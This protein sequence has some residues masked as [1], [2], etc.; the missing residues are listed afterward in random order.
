MANLHRMAHAPIAVRG[1]VRRT[2]QV[3][4]V[5]FRP[6]GKLVVF[7]QGLRPPMND[8]SGRRGALVAMV[9]TVLIWSYSWIVMKQVL[10][11]AG[12]FDFAALRYAGGAALLFA[13]M[14]V[15]RQR[16][17]PPPLWPTIAIGLLQ[18]A[19]F[20]GLGQL[21]LIT[22][23]AG[24]VALLVYAMPFWAVLIAW[25]TMGDAP[26]RR[27]WKGLA[28]AAIG[29]VCVIEPWHGLG[30]ATSTLLALAGGV[31]WA[32]ATVISKRLFQARAVQPLS[33][34]A[35]QMAVGAAAL[36]VVALCI[37]QR[38]IEWAPA[39]IAGLT[40]SVVLASSIA[41]ALWALVVKRLP[42]TVAAISTLAVPVASV[43]L[44]WLLL[45]ETVSPVEG[46][47]I[48]F[49]IAGLAAVTGV[50]RSPRK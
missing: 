20:Q 44:A 17:R 4:V 5:T 36:S 38:P 22:G 47:G 42:T 27:Q 23:G 6:S 21:A 1:E 28:L 7:A 13:G 49:I 2:A 40:Y 10:R 35:W 31:C 32:A 16:M 25:V 14:A 9:I 19:A 45:D 18:T 39:F 8:M 33:L 46:L 34:T 41:W 29:L 11:Y 12:P 50:G 3:A 43:G 15:A 30:N 37:P 48:A 26:T 24:H